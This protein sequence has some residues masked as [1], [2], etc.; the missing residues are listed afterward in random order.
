[1]PEAQDDATIVAI[2][3]QERAGLD[4]V[5][6]GEQRREHYIR[7]VIRGFEGF[8]FANLAEK[9]TRGGRYTVEVPRITGPVRRTAPLLAHDAEVLQTYATRRTKITLPGPLTIMDTSY[10]DYYGDRKALAFDLAAALNAEARDLA[11]AGVDLIQIDEPTFNIYLDD[12]AEFGIA[13]LDR[14]A[15]GVT[16][17]MGVHIC[18][19]Y[20]SPNVLNWKRSNTDWGQY[21]HTLPLLAQSK[22]ENLALEFAAPNLD[23]SILELVGDKKVSMGVIDV[24]YDVLETADD[25]ANRLRRALEF[26][27]PDRL[28][29]STDC[30]MV[31]IERARAY[32]KLRVLVEGTQIIRRELGVA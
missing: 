29:A 25:V 12:V 15:A 1:M 7:H 20:G 4:I 21:R 2:R 30:G 18:Y 31:P 24:S 32:E 23:P 13:A 28:L 16:A 3:E 27:S 22:I 19:G 26:I 6:D 11:T 14:I 9:Q 8:D 5:S 17:E 10:D